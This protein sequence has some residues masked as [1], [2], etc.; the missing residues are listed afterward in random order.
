MAF[1][2]RTDVYGCV[3]NGRVVVLD[4]AADRYFALPTA[5]DAAV[6]DWFNGK[7][8]DP[9]TTSK[10]MTAGL[11]VQSEAGAP[12]QQVALAPARS[13]RLPQ[14]SASLS[15]LPPLFPVF[16][17]IQARHDLKHRPLND[18]ISDIRQHKCRKASHAPPVDGDT[19][20]HITLR[21]LASRRFISG[22]NE[23]LRW[24]IAMVR[25]LSA[26]G[27][28]P[29]L[30]LGVRMMPFGAHAWVQDGDTLLNDTVEQVSAYTPILVV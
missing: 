11:I 29:N 25:Y 3:A 12:R 10:L 18:I 27:Y 5:T 8:L 22:Q 14:Q 6:Q 21:Y 24:S 7:G 30:V 2:F 20:S 23:C 19:L 4:L 16:A 9:A 26:Y 15:L 28:Y 17:Q 13:S 1:A